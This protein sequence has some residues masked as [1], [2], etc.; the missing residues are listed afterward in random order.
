MMF[1]R[2]KETKLL[3][4]QLTFCSPAEIQVQEGVPKEKKGKE[5]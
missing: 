2:Q 4:S 3:P 5:R 1:Q